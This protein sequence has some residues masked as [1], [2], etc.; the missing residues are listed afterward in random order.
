MH[1]GDAPVL[2]GRRVRFTPP[3][4]TRPVSMALRFPSRSGH[5]STGR[6]L[7]HVAHRVPSKNA[8][9]SG[10]PLQEPQSIPRGC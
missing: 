7:C 1:D 2:A 8:V 4:W 5:E 9:L 6:A 3:A 10:E